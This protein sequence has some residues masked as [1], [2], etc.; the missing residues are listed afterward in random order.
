MFHKA[1]RFSN[2]L[3]QFKITSTVLNI[4]AKVIHKNKTQYDVI[5]CIT[6]IRY[7][8]RSFHINNQATKIHKTTIN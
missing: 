8:N 7:K 2:Q 4:D 3:V 1:K 5:L 6:K